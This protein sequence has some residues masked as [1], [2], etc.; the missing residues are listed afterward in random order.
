MNPTNFTRQA[1]TY[2]LSHNL[3]ASCE[4]GVKKLD[5]LVRVMQ[6]SI[7]F[8]LP[9]NGKVIDDSNFKALSGI[10][11]ELPFPVIA[12]EFFWSE[13]GERSGKHVVFADDNGDGAIG[14]TM[15]SEHGGKWVYWPRFLFSKDSFKH[16]GME[17][18][19]GGE[20]FSINSCRFDLQDIWKNNFC[21]LAITLASLFSFLNALACRN[22]H[23]EKLGNRPPKKAKHGA[24]P[25]DEYHVLTISSA[26][27]STRGP[28]TGTHRS[29][30]EHL[31]RGHI[32]QLSNG[33]RVWVNA[34]VV[35]SNIGG[36]V[37]KSYRCKS[38]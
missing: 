28:S 12:L 1:F 35:N 10:D 5:D 23:I 36:K 25:F 15:L 14:I 16:G 30:R 24:L 26:S 37:H 11:I 33:E 19:E 31:R 27:S 32:R 9:D 3:H 4:E 18:L 21:M 34:T 13:K 22:V 7:K 2:F 8:A 17:I 6:G 29:P 20:G 38:F